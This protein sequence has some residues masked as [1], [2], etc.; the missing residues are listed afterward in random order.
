M[1]YDLALVDLLTG[2]VVS[3][4]AGMSY[5]LEGAQLQLVARAKGR[6]PF[7]V[8]NTLNCKIEKLYAEYA[9]DTSRYG[10][11]VRSSG[12]VSSF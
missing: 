5:S 9:T 4:F 8:Y 11:F 1:F 7:D 6:I 10:F 3:T 2:V 12:A